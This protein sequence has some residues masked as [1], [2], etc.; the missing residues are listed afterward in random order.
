M[1]NPALRLSFKPAKNFQVEFMQRA[2]WLASDTDAWVRGLRRDRT[3]TSGGFIGQ[4]T[5]IR[6]IWQLCKNFDL[7]LSYSHFWPGSFVAK[8][9]SAPQGDFIQMAGTL[10]F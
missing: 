4:E 7:D 1:V 2:F 6:L 5:D 10:R 8:T 3:G 9:G